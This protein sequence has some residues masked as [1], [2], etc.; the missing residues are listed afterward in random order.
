MATTAIAPSRKATPKVH[1][2]PTQIAADDSILH[3]RPIRSRFFQWVPTDD[4]QVRL[5]EQRI[6]S[7]LV[8]TQRFVAGINTIS[9]PSW[10]V[11]HTSG[12]KAHTVVLVHGF[13]SG[14]GCWAQN[15]EYLAKHNNV[16]AIDLP[17]FGRSMRDG[18]SFHGAHDAMQYYYDALHVWFGDAGIPP[19][20]P[21]TVVGHSFGGYVLSHYTMEML[22]RKKKLED[23]LGAPVT[24]HDLLASPPGKV[25]PS[26]TC[27]SSNA[28]PAAVGNNAAPGGSNH[29][30]V[31]SPPPNIVHLVLADPWGVPPK[32]KRV[33]PFK[34][35]MLIKLFYKVSPLA[36]L[37]CAGPW[38]PNLLPKVRPDFAE[39]WD[40][41]PDP[42]IFYDYTYHSNAQTPATGELAFQACCEGAAFAKVPL[43]VYIPEML[44]CIATGVDTTHNI[45]AASQEQKLKKESN[46]S[47]AEPHEPESCKPPSPATMAK[48]NSHNNRTTEEPCSKTALPHLTLLHG[49]HTWMDTAMYQRLVDTLLEGGMVGSVT[50]GSIVNAGH[51]LNTDNADDFNRKLNDAI[52]R[53]ARSLSK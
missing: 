51:Q 37:R 20:Q 33:L 18:R 14:L 17:G 29:T 46:D 52:R 41:L 31:V 2:D 3:N 15:W 36:I 12:G 22:W 4:D 40:H 48:P 30:T 39:R 24:D 10:N 25:T 28:A 32:Q 42:L 8:Y 47:P 26:S 44:R 43:L 45:R 16:H 50:I 27:K 19:N 23:A 38:G 49:D 34:F 5:V 6:L 7:G 13:A 1:Q 9:S 35:R 21:V 53:G 11:S